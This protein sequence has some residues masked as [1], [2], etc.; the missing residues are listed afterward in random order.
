M[1]L[2]L[3][4][5][6]LNWVGKREPDIYGTLSLEE[7]LKGFGSAVTVH[8]SNIE[9]DIINALQDAEYNHDISG[10]ILNAGG[11]SHTSIAIAD[12]IRAMKKPVISVHIT[13]I[14]DRESERHK[15]LVSAACTGFIGGFGLRSYD[16][17]VHALSEIS[18]S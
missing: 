8:F 2:I 11:Y 6:N 10:V 12:T 16:L 18:N 5:P 17:A 4:G 1:I 15:D 9:G 13:N 14:F 7:Y 3:N